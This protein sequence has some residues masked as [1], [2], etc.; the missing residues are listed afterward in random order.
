MVSQEFL[1]EIEALEAIYPGSITVQ[2][3]LIYE[4]HF[5]NIIS[6][7]SLVEEDLG[8]D[9][10]YDASRKFPVSV[11]LSFDSGYPSL[12]SQAPRLL[13]IDIKDNI[14]K[15]YTEEI[16]KIL[17]ESLDKIYVAGQ[18]FVFEYIE[19]VELLINEFLQQ[20]KEEYFEQKKF[21]ENFINE[22][23]S[24]SNAEI[25]SFWSQSNP[26]SDRGSTFIAFACEVH[27]ED[28]LIEKL[29]ALRSNRKIAKSNHSMCAWRIKND[30]N[31][32]IQDSD[33]DG[34][35]AAG[36]RMLHL[37]TIMNVWN[38]LLVDVRWFGGTHIGP[39]RFKH[40]NSTSREALIKGKFATD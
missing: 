8:I 13:L 7:T 9:I 22:Q 14:W 3:V 19:H 30:D 23:N 5:P 15:Q 35:T 21:L 34:E 39:D 12:N 31:T 38:C 26:I 29:A 16:S 1:D 37:M 18:V 32:I 6:S 36:S 4:L 2:N 25:P 40:I 33:D 27:D 17:Q 24:K 20:I 10:D 28:E 11:R